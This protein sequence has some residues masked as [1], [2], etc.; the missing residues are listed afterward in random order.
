MR[1]VRV[2]RRVLRRPGLVPL[3]PGLVP[4]ERV[5]SAF[6]LLL[7]RRAVCRLVVAFQHGPP[8]LIHRILIDEIPLVQ[9][10]YEP[11]VRSEFA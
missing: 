2:R 8:G 5:R 7:G 3:R 6:C 4:S 1:S 10:V 9:L 11:L